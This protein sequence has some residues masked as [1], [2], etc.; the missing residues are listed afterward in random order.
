MK[1]RRRVFGR[2]RKDINEESYTFKLTPYGLVIHKKHARVDWQL[3]FNEL[4]AAATGQRVMRFDP[5][6]LEKL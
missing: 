2:I 4:L 3:D 1:R 5:D 6:L